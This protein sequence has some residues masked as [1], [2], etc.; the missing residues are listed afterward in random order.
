MPSNIQPDEYDANAD[1]E[2]AASDQDRHEKMPK[3]SDARKQ[4]VDFESTAADAVA[5]N[6]NES[7]D[8]EA[9]HDDDWRSQP[10]DANRAPSGC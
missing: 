2:N 10:S 6:S 7:I 3:T 9:R 5:E 8:Q 4:S 1:W